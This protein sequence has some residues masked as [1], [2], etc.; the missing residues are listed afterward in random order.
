MLWPGIEGRC[1]IAVRIGATAALTKF[2]HDGLAGLKQK[3]E[4][5]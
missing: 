3:T 1:W 5:K 2:F 4:A